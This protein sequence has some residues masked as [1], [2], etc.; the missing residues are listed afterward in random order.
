M[1]GVWETGLGFSD[2]FS[3]LSRFAAPMVRL[4]GGFWV[5]ELVAPDFFRGDSAGGGGI[6]MGFDLRG[7]GGLFARNGDARSS[8]LCSLLGFTI[9]LPAVLADRPAF[10]SISSGS[11]NETRGVFT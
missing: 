10:V 8:T 1:G 7:R 3:K 2:C 5:A 9:V 6:G 4:A 11:V